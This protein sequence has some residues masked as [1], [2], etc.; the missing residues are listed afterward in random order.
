MAKNSSKE[1]EKSDLTYFLED[2]AILCALPVSKRHNKLLLEE[3]PFDRQLL[4]AS[5]LY[6]ASRKLYLS[7]GGRFHP[8][9]CSTMRSLS[10]QDL[11]KDDI[12][13]SPSLSELMWFKDHV[14]DVVDPQAELV[15][16]S[17]F[18]EISIYHEQ[19]HRIVWRI[20]PPA[21]QEERDLCRYLNFAESLVVTLDL[22][23]GDELGKKLSQTFELM[24]VIYRPGGEDKWHKEAKAIYRQYLLAILSSTYYT[25]EWMNSEDV[26]KAVDYVLP[27]QKKMNKDAVRR[28]LE[29]SEHFTRITNPLWQERHWKEAGA[30]LKKMHRG[31]KEDALYLPEDPLDLE[32]GEFF[33]AHRVFDMFGL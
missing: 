11:F 5:S 18:N 7:L 14:H 4:E 17:R 8:R 21:P 30:K 32:E 6:R 2:V 27:G 15:A 12:E 20:L 33:Y 19:N 1:V 16:L 25:L 26:L 28:G 9:V 29:L 13:Y 22:A 31:S 10:T 3:Y 23:L 24:K